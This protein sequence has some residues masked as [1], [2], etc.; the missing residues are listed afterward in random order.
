MPRKRGRSV[1][2]A[3]TAVTVQK[4][5]LPL[6]V[7]A[8]TAPMNNKNGKSRAKR[9]AF[10]VLL[11]FTSKDNN[12]TDPKQ[13]LFRVCVLVCYNLVVALAVLCGGKT[14]YAFKLFVERCGA[15]KSAGKRYL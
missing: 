10:S 1:S 7:A 4:I 11:S 15:V 12:S 2:D 6:A 3:R 13:F 8:V 14:C 9:S 5:M